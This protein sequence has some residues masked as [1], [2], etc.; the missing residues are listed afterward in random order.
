MNRPARDISMGLRFA[1]AVAALGGVTAGCGGSATGSN[2]LDLIATVDSITLSLDS[3]EVIIG[4]TLR[5]VAIP[6]N[7][8]GQPVTGL[9]LFWIS[10]DPSVATVSQTGLITGVDFGEAE[11]DVAVIGASPNEAPADGRA[12][13][14]GGGARNFKTNVAP[15][16]VIS[17][18]D[19]TIERG[20]TQSY[21]AT[22]TNSKGLPVRTNPPINWRSSSPSVASIISTGPAS[23]DATGV[24]NGT[25]NIKASV[26]YL[27]GKESVP[28]GNSVPLHVAICGGLLDVA[29]WTATVSTAYTVTDNIIPNGTDGSNWKF[30]LNQVSSGTASLHVIHLDT[31][32][33]TATWEGVVSGTGHI[34][35][36]VLQKDKV[37]DNP[38]TFAYT[39]TTEVQAHAAQQAFALVRLTVNHHDADTGCTYDV[40]Y[41]EGLGYTHYEDINY[42]ADV[43]TAIAGDSHPTGS[44]PTAGWRFDSPPTVGVLLPAMLF[45]GSPCEDDS[46]VAPLGVNQFYCPLPP[47]PQSMLTLMGGNHRFGTAKFTYSFIGH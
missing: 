37:M 19:R 38:L 4:D 22:L 31:Q 30:N 28:V 11:I 7:A 17:P 33:G 25:T 29:T 44:K 41:Q 35:N 10:S 9:Q 42:T 8:A 32:S 12:A 1:L 14:R 45:A 43:R 5:L 21:T 15:K 40:Y 3:A 24:G 26:T 34:T 16:I 27:D 39:E 23:A 18:G 20:K 47:I 46:E 6:R 13:T 36:S 2:P